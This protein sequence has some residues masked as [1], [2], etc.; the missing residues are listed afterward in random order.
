MLGKWWLI[1][2]RRLLT[3]F[4]KLV[5]IVGGLGCA[6][7]PIDEDTESTD[8]SEDDYVDGG[9]THPFADHHHTYVQDTILPD[10]WTQ[11]ELDDQV[12]HA[13][14][15]W[16]SRYLKNGC[17]ADEYYIGV[18]TQES[19][20]VSEAHG[21]GMIV[22]AYMA[23]HEDSARQYFDGMA[24]YF[25]RH[26]SECAGGLMAWS[27][28]SNCINNLGACS[29]T[30]GDLDIA[31]AL[32][33]A[34]IQWGSEGPINYR[35]EALKIIEAILHD[36]MDA[37]GGYALLGD[38]TSPGDT[39]YY[40]ATRSSDFMPGHFAS[41]KSFYQGQIWQ[42]IIDQSY[43]MMGELQQIHSSNT[44]LIPDFI[45]SPMQSPRPA[46]S[47]FLERPVDGEYSYNACRVPFRIGVHY[48]ISGDSRAKALLDKM[49]Q[50][51][52]TRTDGN[53]SNITAGYYLNGESLPQSQ[54]QSQAFISP[55]GVAAMVDQANQAWLNN[56]WQYM[57]S[58]GEDGGYYEDTL[59]LLSMIAI[60][61]NWWTPPIEED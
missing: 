52:V 50:W 11:E 37:G 24:R 34:H 27:Q 45:Q 17:D 12:R 48:L 22:L 32:L 25:K 36:E 13:Y 42:Q 53:P 10:S 20:T 60:S 43:Q 21:Y 39:Y 19:I 51:I 40:D 41:F 29:A 14:D 38:W 6:T 46:E 55:F 3:L 2:S 7:Q 44:G 61:G 28:D 30:D 57:I 35:Q 56:I 49:N 15:R 9:V 4:L 59:R 31:Y 1:S 18:D 54:Y 33:L 5:F 26:P 16:Q 8:T 47:N 23:G 58:T